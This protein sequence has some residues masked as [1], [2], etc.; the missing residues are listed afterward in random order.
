MASTSD[1]RL[2]GESDVSRSSCH[3]C[4]AEYLLVKSFVL[5]GSGPYAVAFSA[6]HSHGDPE[7][8]IDVIF[9]AF[10]G[11]AAD[12]VRTT[13][14]CRVGAVESS[15]E[16]AATAVPAAVPYA[17]GPVFG[18]KLNREEALAHPRVADFWQ[19]VD[20]LLVHE[21]AVRHHIY[22]HRGGAAPQQRRPWWRRR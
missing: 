12:D 18:H 14:G 11:D 1:L 22:G 19:V 17:D 20:F 21:S 6:L 2:D 5:D 9:G 15:D 3:D 10:E 16:P 4:G 13:F 8:W 7:A